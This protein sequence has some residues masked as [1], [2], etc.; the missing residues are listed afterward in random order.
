VRYV[1]KPAMGKSLSAPAT[2]LI[3]CG[4]SIM[5]QSS[6][7]WVTIGNRL[8]QLPHSESKSIRISSGRAHRYPRYTRCYHRPVLGDHFLVSCA[9]FIWK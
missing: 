8:L 4:P 5:F 9:L 2:G 3:A 1:R 7:L 6:D